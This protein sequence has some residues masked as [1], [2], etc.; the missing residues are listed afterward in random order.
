MIVGVNIKGN[1]REKNV[2][3]KIMVKI[4]SDVERILDKIEGEIKTAKGFKN[5]CSLKIAKEY[6]EGKEKALDD[7]KTWIQ[8]NILT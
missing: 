7:T 3:R 1:I 6:F 2:R 8:E 5:T 4:K